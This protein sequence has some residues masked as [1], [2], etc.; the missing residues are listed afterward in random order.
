MRVDKIM[1]EDDIVINYWRVE[2]HH[3]PWWMSELSIDPEDKS[4]KWINVGYVCPL[5]T[6]IKP[7]ENVLACSAVNYSWTFN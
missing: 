7:L 4:I 6:A 3:T 5:S 2:S 1:D